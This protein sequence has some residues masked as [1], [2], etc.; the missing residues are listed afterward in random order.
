MLTALSELLELS[1]IHYHDINSG[2][3]SIQILGWNSWRWTE[4]PAEAAPK[5]GAARKALN[6]L[7]DLGERAS[8][9]AP[10]RANQLDALAKKLRAIVEQTNT[11]TGAPKGTV[12]GVRGLVDELAAEYRSTLGGLP[13]AHGAGERLLVPDT[14]ALLD[15]P[16]LQDWKLDGRRWTVTFVPQVRARRPKARPA[17]P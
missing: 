2:N 4:L 16:D 14:S 5:V 15:R 13:S 17:D 3:S 6:E 12:E 1:D 10:D 8:C 9:D 7:V 11:H